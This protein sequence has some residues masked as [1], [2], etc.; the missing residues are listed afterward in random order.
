M[1]VAG[2]GREQLRRIA[3]DADQRMHV[4]AL[5]AAIARD[6]AAGMLPFLLVGTA[7]SV[8]VGA[9]DPLEELAAIAA[10]EGL[11]FHVDGALGALAMLAPALAPRLA[12][13]ERADSLA[14]DWHKWAQ[15]PYDAGFLLVR[16]AAL[17][18]ATFATDAA[19]L[20]RAGRGLAAGAW[21]PC[22]HGLDLSRGFRALKVWFTLK[23]FGAAAI[24]RAIAASVA[25]AGDLARRIA[26][27]PELEL[28]APVP[29]N[30]VC[31]GSRGADADR[32]NA[33]LVVALQ[34]AGRVAPSL[35]RVGGRC[36]IRAAMVNHRT[37]AADCAALVDSVLERLRAQRVPQAA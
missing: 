10:A 5:R 16:D 34:E 12:G 23:T 7:G 13:I 33:D 9:I 14:F 11:H 8:D 2:L 18:R 29:L 1:E 24:G 22:D 28:L 36:A 6:R 37:T 35:T 27:E 17:Q 19:Y 20:G 15:V 26:A 30:I 21:W 3:V 31:F 32:R 25:L 4:P